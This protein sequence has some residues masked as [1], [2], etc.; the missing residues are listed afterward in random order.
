[1]ATGFQDG[2]RV[3]WQRFHKVFAGSPLQLPT[4]PPDGDT[5]QAIYM[6]FVRHYRALEYSTQQTRMQHASERRAK[7]PLLIYRD[8]Q[9]ERAEPVQMIATKSTFEI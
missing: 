2:F 6:E 5:A 8:L 1:M 9:K 4:I 7:D 3:W